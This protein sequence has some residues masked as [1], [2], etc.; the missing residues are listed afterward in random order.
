M[1]E[2]NENSPT[3]KRSGVVTGFVVLLVV[4]GISGAWKLNR[5]WHWSWSYKSQ[6]A[7]LIQKEMQPLIER[8]EVLEKKHN[9]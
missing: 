7:A 6:T 8:I 1:T 3:S 4:C 5:W 9:E 2:K